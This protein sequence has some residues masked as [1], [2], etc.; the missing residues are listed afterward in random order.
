MEAPAGLEVLGLADLEARVLA[1]PEARVLA[2]DLEAL[3]VGVPGLEVLGLGAGLGPEDRV[4]SGL[5]AGFLV[6]LQMASATSYLHGELV[7]QC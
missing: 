7:K 5:G 4:G 1:D 3:L 2:Q 6:D